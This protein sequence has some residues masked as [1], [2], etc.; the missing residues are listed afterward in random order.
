MVNILRQH[1]VEVSTS[2]PFELNTELLLFEIKKVL[3]R[4]TVYNTRTSGVFNS[5][6]GRPILCMEAERRKVSGPHR[7]PVHGVGV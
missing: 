2:F 4:Y 7:G 5:Q 1:G 3:D 6:R